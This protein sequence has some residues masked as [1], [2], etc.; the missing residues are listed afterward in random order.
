[1]SKLKLTLSLQ[2]LVMVITNLMTEK[3]ASSCTLR[4]PQILSTSLKGDNLS[5]SFFFC[6]HVVTV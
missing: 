4:L 1:M 2:K 6:N 3:E 5:D